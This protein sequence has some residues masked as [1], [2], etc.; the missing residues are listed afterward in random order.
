VKESAVMKKIDQ[1]VPEIKDGL[2]PSRAKTKYDT[3][4]VEGELIRL[5]ERI[6]HGQYVE[7]SAGSQ[8]KFKAIVESRGLKTVCRRA[9]GESRGIVFV[10]TPEWL[11]ENPDV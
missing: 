4:I 7:I 6:K 11:A 3:K 8:G 5:A 2:P 10:V 1:Y 9:Q